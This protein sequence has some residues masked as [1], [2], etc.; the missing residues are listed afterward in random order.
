MH[1]NFTVQYM[2]IHQ[3]YSYFILNI[4]FPGYIYAFILLVHYILKYE[5]ISEKI[6]NIEI[7]I[8]NILNGSQIFERSVQK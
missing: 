2:Y 4:F 7:D 5:N 1:S 3:L 8:G 6:F